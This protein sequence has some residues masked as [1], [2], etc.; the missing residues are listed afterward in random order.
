MDPIDLRSDTVTRPTPAMRAA[1][2]SAEVGDDQYG[3]DPTVNRLQARVAE[4]LGKE[5]ALFVPTGTMANQI[6]LRLLT[7]PGDDV[8]I[9]GESHIAWH[10]AGASGANAGVQF[11]VASRRALHRRRVRSRGEALG[12]ADLRADHAGGDR[13]HPQ[14]LRRRHLPAGRRAAPGRRRAARNCAA[15]L[16]GARLFNAAV[17]TGLSLAELAAPFDL[18]LGRAVQ[19]PRLPGR[20]SGRRARATCCAGRWRC[21]SAWAARCASPAF[22]P[23]PAMSRSMPGSAISRPITRTPA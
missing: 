11:M 8:V 3:E 12:Q 22:S 6:G 7:R 5:A 4:L 2:A 1:M 19:G 17:A 13:E 20:Q 14:P 16:D 10:E 23:P 18:G 15:Y 21:A 9:G